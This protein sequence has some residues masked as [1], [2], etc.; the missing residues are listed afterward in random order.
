[1]IF[2]RASLLSGFILALFL[3]AK[4]SKNPT[5]YVQFSENGLGIKPQLNP[6]R[7]GKSLEVIYLYYKNL[8]IQRKLKEQNYCSFME[9]K[10]L[11]LACPSLMEH[12]KDI[13]EENFC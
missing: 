5:I 2:K 8:H 13:K 9:K 3:C 7:D 1:M 6:Q 4:S 10:V 11:L 12:G